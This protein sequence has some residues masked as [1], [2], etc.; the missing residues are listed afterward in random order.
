MDKGKYG[1]WAVLNRCV[2]GG[3]LS[4]TQE[5]YQDGGGRS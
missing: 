2:G 3:G 4:I 1:L 5:I